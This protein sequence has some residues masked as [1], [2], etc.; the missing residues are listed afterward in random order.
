MV[1]KFVLF[2][3]YFLIMLIQLQLWK[4][5]HFEWAEYLV[6]HFHFELF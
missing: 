3:K 6:E 5:T 4:V 1:L 2:L